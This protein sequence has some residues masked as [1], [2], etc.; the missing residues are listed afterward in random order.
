LANVAIIALLNLLSGVV[1]FL[2]SYYAY[3]NNRLVGSILLRYISVG[4]LLLG[5]SLV[6][7]AG[8][9]R[10]VGLTPVEAFRT[11]GLEFII[12]LVYTAL[13]LIA[14]GVFAWG[15]GLSA[16]VRKQAPAGA[17]VPSLVLSS[18]AKIL[19]SALLTL[20]IYIASQIGVIILLMIIVAQGVRVF[21]HSKSNLAFM[22]MFG[23]AL[24]FG[25]HLLMLGG[26]LASEGSVFLIG[27]T[28]EFCGFL[29][30]LFF[31]VWS[32][33]IVK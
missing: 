23:F 32:G 10:V 25:G 14:Y 13:Q 1:A 11:R 30:L 19:A 9:E 8:T 22:V 6:L 31:L 24:I 7:Q 5:V 2:I 33:R 15:Y 16:F 17:A 3:K 18:P 27:T 29:G 12:F 21:S 28:I 20:A 26:V 4:F